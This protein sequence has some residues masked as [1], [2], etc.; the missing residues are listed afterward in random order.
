MSSPSNPTRAPAEKGPF[1]K[2]DVMKIF[3]I[4]FPCSKVPFGREGINKESGG[5]R[6]KEK[7]LPQKQASAVTASYKMILSYA[8]CL[9]GRHQH[10]K[11]QGICIPSNPS[12][13]GCAGKKTGDPLQQSSAFV[14][15]D[16]YLSDYEYNNSTNNLSSVCLNWFWTLINTNS[17]SATKAVCFVCG[18]W[19]AATRH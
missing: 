18:H 17:P 15:T 8:S 2:R 1:P 12:S 16:S 10:I 19:R 13:S 9:W 11:W 4:Q 5:G 7:P 6:R 14:L 3:W